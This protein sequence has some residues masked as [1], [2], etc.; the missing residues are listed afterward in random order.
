INCRDFKF[1]S[2]F[3]LILHYLHVVEIEVSTTYLDP[4][5]ILH[6]KLEEYTF[7]ERLLRD[8]KNKE[9]NLKVSISLAAAQA[10]LRNAMEERDQFD[11]A[12]NQIVAHLK[13]GR[14]R[15]SQY[16]DHFFGSYLGSSMVLC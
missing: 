2:F 6:Y 10:S 4:T 5:Y 16:K 13:T 7:S 8:W 11:E 14:S 15:C 9:L 1:F 12:N 3:F